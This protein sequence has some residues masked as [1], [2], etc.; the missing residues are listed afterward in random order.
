MT[1]HHTTAE[2]KQI[3]LEVILEKTLFFIEDVATFM[4]INK[5]TFYDHKLNEDDEIKQAILDNKI[6]AKQGLRSKWYKSEAPVLQVAL[7]KLIGSDD[8]YHRLANTLMKS[9]VT[10]NGQTISPLSINI[11]P[12]SA[13][14][15]ETTEKDDD[16]QDNLA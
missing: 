9:D 11:F 1:E 15:P 3:A 5:N 8:E 7:Y 2:W 13:A 16:N 4:G 6:N 14:T 10:S 12:V